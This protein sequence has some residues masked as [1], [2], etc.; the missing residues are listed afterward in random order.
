MQDG[1]GERV[2]FHIEVPAGAGTTG[3]PQIWYAIAL[4]GGGLTL[5]DS[6]FGISIGNILTKTLFQESLA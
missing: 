3:C 5:T 2:Y 4:V 6:G 1:E